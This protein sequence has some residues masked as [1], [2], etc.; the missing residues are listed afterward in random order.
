MIIG[1]KT[2]ELG[3]SGCPLSIMMVRFNSVGLSF[4]GMRS[5]MY[6]YTFLGELEPLISKMWSFFK[7]NGGS[8][9]N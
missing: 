9:S 8:F 4:L 6:I 2:G 3:K 1:E 7:L 5:N